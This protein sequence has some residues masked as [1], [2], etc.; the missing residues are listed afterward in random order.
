MGAE[1][2]PGPGG[3]ANDAYE[4][5]RLGTARR[6]KPSGKKTKNCAAVVV[7]IKELSNRKRRFYKSEQLV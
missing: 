5:E 4:H 2:G 3:T 1:S 6:G 7:G